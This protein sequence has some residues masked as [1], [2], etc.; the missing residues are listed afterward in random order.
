V[1][2]LAKQ[3]SA[4]L[5]G[6]VD[7]KPGTNVT[8]TQTGQTLEVAA[9]SSSTSA[10]VDGLTIHYN[11][12]SLEVMTGTT[13]NKILKLDSSAKIPAVDG[14]QLTNIA[15]TSIADGAVTGAKLASNISIATTGTVS[16]ETSSTYG[17]F[18]KS[19][20]DSGAGVYGTANGSVAY[21]L[22]GIA[23]GSDGAGVYGV[24]YGSSGSGILGYY[25]NASSAGVAVN[26]LNFGGDH[27]KAGM[28]MTDNTGASETYGVY[29]SSNSTT[30]YG[31][32][33]YASSSSGTNYGGYFQTNSST[34]YSGYFTG[35]LGAKVIG[36]MEA[37]YLKGDGSQITGV[38][39][40]NADTVDNIHASTTATASYLFPLDSSARFNLTGA[41]MSGYVLRASNSMTQGAAISGEA[42]GPAGIGIYG[43][44]TDPTNSPNYGGLFISKGSESHG[45]Y[46]V[47]TGTLSHGV[48]GDAQATSGLNYG[49][50]GR[51]FSDAGY[52]GYFTGGLGVKV[53]T[54]TL[55]APN[56]KIAS[57]NIGS[58]TALQI[59]ALG[60]VVKSSSSRRYK[61]NINPLTDN[62]SLILNAEPKSYTYKSS[63]QK[64]I[65]YIAEDFDAAGLKDLVIY[66]KDGQ[67]DALKYDK[68]A[69]YLLEIIK[70]QQKDIDD[71]K[72]RLTNK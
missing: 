25:N 46:G 70:Q 4:K 61:E 15:A 5:T 18:G 35:G 14:S 62:F 64:D 44:A 51:T 72:K 71:L 17:V 34:G 20:Y 23:T 36:T 2:S 53:A 7:I 26:G 38:T 33:G 22:E 21:G 40:T 41:Q 30:G 31:V 66:N 12:T 19:T 50:Y 8:L 32:Y 48:Y 27:S 60:G 6:A 58:G 47:A 24:G 16:V 10:E 3:G 67:P 9:S 1:T 65:G 11:G 69:V 42:T 43:L 37:T 52:S 28:F 56:I 59:D 49:V 29:G 54:G 39:V 45:V 68:I 63:G 13:A 57:V 55:E